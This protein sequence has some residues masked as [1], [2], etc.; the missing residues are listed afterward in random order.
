MTKD[1]QLLK[2]LEYQGDYG[3]R[4]TCKDCKYYKVKS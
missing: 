3:G 1:W 2:S 4:Y